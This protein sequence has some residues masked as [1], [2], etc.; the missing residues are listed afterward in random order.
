M[1]VP[2]DWIPEDILLVKFSLS[3]ADGQIMAVDDLF[4]Q[5]AVIIRLEE[6]NLD[7]D[8]QTSGFPVQSVQVS[9]RGFDALIELIAGSLVGQSLV[10]SII[11]NDDTG[12]LMNYIDE[13]IRIDDLALLTGGNKINFLIGNDQADG[14]SFFQNNTG[15]PDNCMIYQ[16]LFL[17]DKLVD[18]MARLT[19]VNQQILQRMAGKLLVDIQIEKVRLQHVFHA[20]II[21]LQERYCQ[22]PA[23]AIIDE[24]LHMEFLS[25]FHRNIPDFISK[26]AGAL[27]MERLKKVG[28][29]CGCEYTSFPIFAGKPAYDRYQHSVGVSLIVWHFTHDEAQTLSGLF[30]D[31]ATPCFSH[32]IDFLNRDHMKQESTEEG[33]E[34]IIAESLEIRKVLDEEGLS[35]DQ[36]SDYHQY[37]IADNDSPQLSADRLEYT[38][39]NLVRYAGCRKEEIRTFY[40]DLTVADN[41]EGQKEL[42]FQHAD[43]AVSF[44]RKALVTGKIYSADPDRYSMEILAAVLREALERGVISRPDLYTTEEQIIARLMADEHSARLWNGFRSLSQLQISQKRPVGEEGWYCINTKK[45]FIDPYVK[46]LGRVSS[47]NGE[48]RQELNDSVSQRF[49]YW[50]KGNF[51]CG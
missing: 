13:F 45:R 6:G 15:I 41:E 29:D 44:A 40:E 7:E 32:V 48:F 9:D 11:V 37:P 33:T 38:L 27:A 10:G 14:H 25:V 43:L 23:H 35:I 31:I 28:M 34:R 20:F 19:I 22:M 12:R 30:H 24:R 21:V 4:L 36:V 42:C 1:A 46:G 3:P 16:Q 8:N 18:R 47:L 51:T 26:A 2:A 50:M 17:T 39:R 49:D 5:Q